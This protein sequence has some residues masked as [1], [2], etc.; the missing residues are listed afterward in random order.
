MK[1]IKIKIA[2][3]IDAS[4]KWSASGWGVENKPCKDVPMDIAV[5]G[6][7]EGGRRYWVEAEIEVPEELTIQGEVFPCHLKPT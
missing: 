3:A 2:V 6:V 5:E 4:G 1:T 7:K